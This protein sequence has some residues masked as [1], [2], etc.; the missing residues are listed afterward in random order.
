M[1]GVFKQK[2][3]VNILILLLFGLLI[4]LPMFFSPHIPETSTGDGIFFQNLLKLLQPAGKNFPGLYPLLAFLLL[5]IQ[6]VT[7]TSIINSKRMM[8]NSNYLTGMS[9]FV[10]TSLLPEWNY[11]SAPLLV[12]TLLI[13]LI[14]I[15]LKS[16]HLQQVKGIMYNAGFLLGI[17][18]FFYYPAISFVIWLLLAMMLLRPFR[19]NEWILCILGILTPYYFY[20]IYLFLSDEWS[21]MKLVPPFSIGLPAVKQSAWL[22]GSAF[23]LAVP[24]LSGAYFVQN[25]LRKMLIPVRKGWSLLLLFLLASVFVPFVNNGQS[26]E[27]W[28]IAAVPLAAFHACS[29]RY[30][31]LRIIPNLLFWLSVVFIVAY[32]YSGP[33]W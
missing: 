28:V 29:Y 22:A 25:N 21:W 14:S 19:I 10:I 26:F 4:K 30:F 8:N 27:N 17:A 5:L 9:Y 18:S 20:G 31:T 6:S 16:Y 32:Q 24:F 3:P 23:L 15:L 7:I 13:F 1:I 2:N 33:G 11:F 12:N